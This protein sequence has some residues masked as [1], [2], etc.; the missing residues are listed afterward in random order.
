PNPLGFTVLTLPAASTSHPKS[1]PFPAARTLNPSPVAGAAP[2]M[3]QQQQQQQ[4]PL[5]P[6]PPQH[7]PP[8]PGGGGG[9]DFYRGPLQPPMRQLSAASSTNLAP[10]YAGHPG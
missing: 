3:M 8:Q 1:A 5:P 10:D 2:E 6:P 4:Q 7:P 9:G